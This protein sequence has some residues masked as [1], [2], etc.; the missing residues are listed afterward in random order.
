RRAAARGQAA[1]P[2]LRGLPAPQQPVLLPQPAP[3]GRPTARRMLLPPRTTRSP[4]APR[5]T[6]KPPEPP[7]SPVSAGVARELSCVGRWAQPTGEI[8]SF[9]PASPRDR[10]PSVP[11]T[12]RS[13]CA[14]SEVSSAVLTSGC[15]ASEPSRSATSRGT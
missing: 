5:S 13:T 14:A 12:E 8:A 4:T 9:L 10:C 11:A 1:A 15:P 7:P 6:T 3:P 2:Q